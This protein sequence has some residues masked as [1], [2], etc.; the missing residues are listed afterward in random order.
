VRELTRALF[1]AGAIRFGEFTLSSGRRSSYYLNLRLL[2]S[3]RK[4]WQGTLVRKVV[5]AYHSVIE[6]VGAGKVDIVLGPAYAS[7]TYLAGLTLLYGIRTGYGV[8]EEAL[9]GHGVPRWIYAEFTD[10]DHVL[11]L[12]DVMSS[13]GSILKLDAQVEKQCGVDNL[14]V[15]AKDV[16]VLVDRQEGRSVLEAHR[17]A[18]APQGLKVHSFTTIGQMCDI[19][20]GDG[21]ITRSVRNLVAKEIREKSRL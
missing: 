15:S 21:L 6:D 5:E 19:L 11:Y 20:V 17:S 18:V 7:I 14:L 10:G 13:G 16:V 4:E 3:V 9:K 1:D 12:D 8:K 2:T